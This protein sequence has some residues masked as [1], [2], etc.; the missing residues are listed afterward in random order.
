MTKTNTSSPQNILHEYTPSIYT[1]LPTQIFFHSPVS[2]DSFLTSV[3]N[4]EELFP[5][6]PLLL[7]GTSI[8]LYYSLKK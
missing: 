1:W 7:W 5:E 6:I 2:L 3:V 8:S 4:A